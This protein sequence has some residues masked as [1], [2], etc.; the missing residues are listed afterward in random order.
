M[1]ATGPVVL[2]VAAL[3]AGCS[4]SS[5]SEQQADAQPS[6]ARATPGAAGSPTA[7]VMPQG[8]RPSSAAA[9]PA[10]ASTPGAGTGK[11]VVPASCPSAGNEPPNAAGGGTQVTYAGTG[12]GSYS[13]PDGT[14]A[15][16]PFPPRWTYVWRATEHLVELSATDALGVWGIAAAAPD[17]RLSRVSAIY[18]TAPDGR[19]G[20]LTFSMRLAAALPLTALAPG[21]SASGRAADDSLLVTVHRQTSGTVFD[22]R[23]RAGRCP[24]SEGMGPG[25]LSLA[26]DG[27]GPPWS[28]MRF[29]FDVRVENDRLQGSLQ[30]RRA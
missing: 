20:S 26:L 15:S 30:L 6:G 16:Y 17:E 27:A 2:A 14:G 13:A 21:A 18:L 7:G 9:D 22:V 4:S 19:G 11:V 3:L 24:A 25:T 28:A 29:G 10:G 12:T 1:R 23:L 8:T 5:S